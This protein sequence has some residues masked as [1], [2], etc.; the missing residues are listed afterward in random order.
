MIEWQIAVIFHAVKGYKISRHCVVVDKEEVPAIV[1]PLKILCIGLQLLILS[2]L[3][4]GAG[5]MR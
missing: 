1:I 5:K 4:G 2:K 3:N